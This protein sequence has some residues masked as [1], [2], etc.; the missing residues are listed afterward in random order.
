MSSSVTTRR[1]PIGA[2]CGDVGTNFRVWAPS[3]RRVE[4]VTPADGGRTFRLDP[5]RDGYFAGVAPGVGAGTL[6]GL[7]LDE[8]ERLLP[9]PASRYQ[10]DGPHGLSQVVDPRAFA[11][12]DAGW[13]GVTLPGQV[14]YEMH[15]GTFTREGTWAA[16]ARELAELK[17]VGI[18]IVEVMPVADFPGTFG[19]G[20]DGVNLFAPTRLYGTPDDFRSFV[21]T[22]HAQGLGVIL[23]VVYNHFGPD[24]NYIHEFSSH[25]ISDVEGEW[26]SNINFDGERA[27]PVREFFVANAGYWIDEFHLDGLRLDATQCIVDTSPEH[28]IAAIVRRA[29][30]AAGRRSVLIV[31]ENEAQTTRVARDPG[32]GGYGADALW[33]DDYHHSALVALTGHNDAYYS[34]HHGT[35][36]EFVSAV[37]WGYL[38][39]GQRYAWQK[40]RRGTP[41]IDL[42]PAAFVVFIENHDQVANSATGERMHQLTS[43]GRYRALVALT[44]L[45]PGTPMLF[46]GQE[47]A[48]SSP[49]LFFADHRGD[50]GVKVREGRGKFLSQFVTLCGREAQERL[51]DPTDRR[52]FERCRLDFTERET[53]AATYRLYRDLLA[54]RRAEP[55]FRAQ[56]PR[57]VDGAVLN[58]RA[59]VLRFFGERPDEDRLLVVNL[60]ADIKVPAIPEPLLA[61]PPRGRWVLQL[62]TESA[63]YGGGGAPDVES[64]QGWHIPAESA[65]VLG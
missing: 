54:L 42:P 43:P 58:D 31:A 20:Y 8:S 30:D 16:A 36:Q 61:P 63:E 44:L 25:Y 45:A 47:F 27:G 9:D 21:D 50:L 14:I 49:F 46:Q 22:A 55:A 12:T 15:V 39:Q 6:Y 17:R 1:M 5:E 52:T 62:T 24:G 48:A 38:F 35:A 37:K 32:L 4:V 23:D 64:E 41:A 34:D 2:E 59:F 40:K 3:A 7:R 53:H 28:V 65:T 56:R 60:G 11:W 33:N 13:R 29:R 26:G 51:A 10:P 18:S 19:W 57:G